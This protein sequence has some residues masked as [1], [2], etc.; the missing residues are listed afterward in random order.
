AVVHL[1]EGVTR[2]GGDLLADHDHL[3]HAHRANS[4]SVDGDCDDNDVLLVATEF[5]EVGAAAGDHVE[6]VR[7]RPV[8]QGGQVQVLE[9]DAGD[10]LDAVAVLA[11]RV[12]GYRHHGPGPGPG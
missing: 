2:P 7:T 1:C 4:R 5:R 6:G 9:G 11:A 8:E 3:V 10:G 12:F